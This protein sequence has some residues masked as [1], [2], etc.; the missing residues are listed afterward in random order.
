MQLPGWPERGEGGFSLI[1]VLVAVTILG[2]AYVAILQSFSLSLHNL[3]RMKASRALLMQDYLQFEARLVPLKEGE[4]KEKERRGKGEELFL[5]GGIYE[6]W[7]LESENGS[8]NSLKLEKI[9]L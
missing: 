5:K 1:E 6:L 8:F 3:G 2:V 7:H 4:M 9:L